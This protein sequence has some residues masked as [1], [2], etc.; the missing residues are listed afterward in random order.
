MLNDALREFS[1]RLPSEFIIDEE[2]EI[3]SPEWYYPSI[4]S[5]IS[6]NLD[7]YAARPSYMNILDPTAPCSEPDTSK[8][9]GIFG[10]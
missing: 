10:K 9:D 8:G 6:R 7:E 4:I 5:V 3:S 1:I 2:A